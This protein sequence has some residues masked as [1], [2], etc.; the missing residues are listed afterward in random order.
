MSRITGK[1]IGKRDQKGFLGRRK[2]FVKIQY[3]RAGLPIEQSLWEYEV[4]SDMYQTTLEGA[5]VSGELQQV[6]NS[7]NHGAFLRLVFGGCVAIS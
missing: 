1:V 6:A 3:D 2:Y 7:F 4:G 5:T